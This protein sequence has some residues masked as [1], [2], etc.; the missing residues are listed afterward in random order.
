MARFTSRYDED[1][2]YLLTI[3]ASDST[4]K[5]PLRFHQLQLTKARDTFRPL[6]IAIAALVGAMVRAS[7]LFAVV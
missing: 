5:P 6:L 4:A 1:A 7:S 2:D 3:T